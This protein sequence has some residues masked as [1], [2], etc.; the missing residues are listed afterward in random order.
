MSSQ[1]GSTSYD[2]DLV[3]CREYEGRRG[4]EADDGGTE[5]GLRLV[6]VC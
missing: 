5:L 2:L 4:R 6:E 3:G 1:G